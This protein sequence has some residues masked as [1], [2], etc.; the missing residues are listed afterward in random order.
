MADFE[1]YEGTAANIALEIERKLIALGVDYRDT[2][3]LRGLAREA[4]EY[5]KGSRTGMPAMGSEKS[6][7]ELYGLI[8]LMFTTM[9]EGA[10][11][12]RQLHGSDAWK[13]MAKAMWAEKELIEGSGST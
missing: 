7:V 5:E 11:H 6:K 4:F 2:H 13:A 10:Q 9:R 8:G 1:N 3:A 12:G